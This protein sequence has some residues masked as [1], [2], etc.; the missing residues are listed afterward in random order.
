MELA[1]YIYRMYP[2]QY[3]SGLSKSIE[4]DLPAAPELKREWLK[5]IAET[6]YLF[7]PTIRDY[8]SVFKKR[9]LDPQTIKYCCQDVVHLA[10]LWKVYATKICNRA[11]AVFGDI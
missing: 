5:V 7:N 11:T 2:R 9:P 10:E 6:K 1:A 4:K 8:Q 3:L